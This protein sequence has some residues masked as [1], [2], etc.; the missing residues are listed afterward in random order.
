MNKYPDHKFSTKR[1]Q[2]RRRLLSIVL[3]WTNLDHMKISLLKHYKTFCD[4]KFNIKSAFTL[5]EMKHYFSYIEIYW[6]L[7]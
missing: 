6:N 5:L 3:S 7:S 2:L 4:K 1:T